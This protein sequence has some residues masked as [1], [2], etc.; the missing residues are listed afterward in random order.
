V[1][2]CIGMPL[3]CFG[4]LLDLFWAFLTSF[5]ALFV[6]LWAVCATV[7]SLLSVLLFSGLGECMESSWVCFMA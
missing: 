5:S 1:C 6:Q 2:M 4:G 7:F 3:M